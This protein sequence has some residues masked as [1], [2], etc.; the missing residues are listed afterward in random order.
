VIQTD[1]RDSEHL[2]LVNRARGENLLLEKRHTLSVQRDIDQMQATIILFK[3]PA[4]PERRISS[5]ALETLHEHLQELHRGPC[6]VA[7][8]CN[9]R[10]FRLIEREMPKLAA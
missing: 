4:E 10:L 9:T 3:H 7:R 5:R 2:H 6:L 8:A 1:Y